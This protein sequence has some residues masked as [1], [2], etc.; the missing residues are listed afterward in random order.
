MIHILYISLN[1]TSTSLV[2]Q[3]L[4]SQDCESSLPTL[5]HLHIYLPKLILV[6]I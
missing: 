3:L 2:K 4:S 5:K 6:L 1:N